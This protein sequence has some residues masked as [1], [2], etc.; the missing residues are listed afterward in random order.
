MKLRTFEMERW[1]SVYENSVDCNL[2]ESGVHP[3]TLE[4]V[5]F[6]PL[7]LADIRLFYSPSNGTER[8]RTLAA[9]LYEGATAQNIFVTIGGAEANFHA[10]IRLLEPGDEALLILPNYMQVHGIVESFGG[11]VIP[12]WSRLENNW[13]PDPDEIA[14]KMTSKTKFISLSNPNN[15]SAIV[16]PLDVIKSIAAVADIYGSWIL[17]DEVYRGAERNGQRSPS[18]WGVY[19][20]TII[21]QSL[22]KAYGAPGLRLGWMVA[23]EE[24]IPEFWAQADYLKIAPPTFSDLI[25]CRVL[26]NRE[27]L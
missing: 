12:V 1:Q 8:F 3:A 24:L 13:L 23:P 9:S 11:R 14:R 21:T 20:K 4:E 25:G 26:Q 7:E 10:V 5:G 16:Y 22:S 27:K 6:D 15:P 19:P 18:F 17:S 2:S